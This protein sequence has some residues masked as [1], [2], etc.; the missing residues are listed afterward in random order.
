MSGFTSVQEALVDVDV[1]VEKELGHLRTPP[2]VFT[3]WVDGLGVYHYALPVQFNQ[4]LS[5]V[6]Q[7]FD[8]DTGMALTH[9]VEALPFTLKLLRM[10]PG[11]DEGLLGIGVRA[12]GFR[13]AAPSDATEEE[14]NQIV[15]A[16]VESAECN[17]TTF[18][19]LIGRDG[20]HV[21]SE[22]TCGQDT[23][24]F[25]EPTEV[26]VGG[27]T[28]HELGLILNAMVPED[29]ALPSIEGWGI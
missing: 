7:L 8:G 2:M 23:E 9:M 14:I 10:L 15:E 25:D 6:A 4:Y 3:V 16:K 28:M 20:H 26:G 21:H 11:A 24:F 12:E 13:V 18:V 29:V 1:A 19:H 17:H 5:V 27:R 22:R